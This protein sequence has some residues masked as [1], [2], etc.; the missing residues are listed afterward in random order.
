MIPT[1]TNEI[2]LKILDTFVSINLVAILIN[3]PELGITD[4]PSAP[5]AALRR[6]LTMQ[7]VATKE[8]ALTGGYQRS[9]I[10]LPAST[11]DSTDLN[12]SNSSG[13]A[14]FQP[15]ST[16]A[17]C[18]HIVYA[19]G[20]NLSGVDPSNGNNRG[21]TLGTVIFVEPIVGAPL[22]LSNP[23]V[24]QHNFTFSTTTRPII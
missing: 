20:A 6:A 12:R 16:F 7:I 22:T 13:I 19:R 5:Q 11:P 8:L 1:Y 3:Y 4:S 10:T 24:F 18:T 21:N 17:P 15:I 14:T 23:T 9:I 2:R